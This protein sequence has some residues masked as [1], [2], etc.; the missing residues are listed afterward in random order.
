MTSNS[1]LRSRGESDEVGSSKI[2]KLRIAAKRPS[3][4]H[5]L[6]IADAEIAHDGSRIEI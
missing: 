2:E 5:Q 6:A 1:R 4:F 3:D